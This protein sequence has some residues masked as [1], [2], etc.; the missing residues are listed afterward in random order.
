MPSMRPEVHEFVRASETLLSPAS[1]APPLTK[2]ECEVVEYYATTLTDH[3]QGM[4]YK[5]NCDNK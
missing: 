4:G 3:C 1:M 5:D 2:E